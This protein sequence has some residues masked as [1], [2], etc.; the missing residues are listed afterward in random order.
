MNGPRKKIKYLPS[1]FKLIYIDQFFH[2]LI[3]LN[4]IINFSESMKNLHLN[5]LNA[6]SNNRGNNGPDRTG[7]V[8]NNCPDNYST[9][10]PYD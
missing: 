10:G 9:W 4:I 3:E 2:Y 5:Y 8:L 1:S 7:N 6:I